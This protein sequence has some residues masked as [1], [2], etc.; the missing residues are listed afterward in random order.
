MVIVK[1]INPL[2]LTDQDF[3][4]VSKA[5]ARIVMV[6]CLPV[7]AHGQLLLHVFYLVFGLVLSDDSISKL[8][9]FIPEAVPP[10]VQLIADNS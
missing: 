3:P 8:V 4:V 6:A 9:T 2:G 1:E 10:K 5:L 7:Q